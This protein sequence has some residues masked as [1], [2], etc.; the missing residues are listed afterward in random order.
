[1]LELREVRCLVW[2]A[3]AGELG[4]QRRDAASKLQ[5]GFPRAPGV[6]IR[7]SPQDQRLADLNLL[8]AAEDP[9]DP[10]L[11]SQRLGAARSR[12]LGVG[13]SIAW[14]HCPDASASPRPY[15]SLTA[16]ARSAETS[17]T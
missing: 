4:E 11:R 2:T 14:L 6:K 5:G 10:L 7:A 8:V 3:G 17:G 1:M 16:S 12:V 9:S 15:P 13:T